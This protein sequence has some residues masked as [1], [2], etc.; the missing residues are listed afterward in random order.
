MEGEICI[1]ADATSSSREKESDQVDN[2]YSPYDNNGN[3]TN[4][5][6]TV[7]GLSTSTTYVYDYDNRLTS[8]SGSI[9]SAFKYDYRSRRYYRSTPTETNTCV[10]DGG[11]CVQEYTQ[12][13]AIANLQVEY[14]RGP[15][16]GGGVGGMVYSIRKDGNQQGQIICSH[17]DHRGDVIARS[18]DNGS[19]TWF[20]IYEAYGTRPFEWGTNLDRQK[21]NTKDEE[22]EL[23]LLN[24][25]MRYRDLE[26]GT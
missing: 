4:K 10:F 1:V 26:T 11:L 17:S 6:V 15:D 9:V 8:T 12:T 16:L 22:A 7:G 24:E 20:A 19:L 14:L 2:R 18:D 13:P 25:G 3:R 23:G 21:A 5:T